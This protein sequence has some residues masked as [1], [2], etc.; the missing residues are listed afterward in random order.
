MA[1]IRKEQKEQLKNVLL[2]VSIPAPLMNELKKTKKLC[3]DNKLYFD[4]KPD[5]IAALEKAIEEAQEIVNAEK[6]ARKN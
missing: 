3:R 1:V 4:V 6:K 5:I 2:R